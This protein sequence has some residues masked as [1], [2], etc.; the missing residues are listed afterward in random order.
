MK[1]VQCYELFGGIALKKLRLFVFQQCQH[2]V[3]SGLDPARNGIL[4][5]P[6]ILPV[7]EFVC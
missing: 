5:G 3:A 6:S 4:S 2:D 7:L 1:G